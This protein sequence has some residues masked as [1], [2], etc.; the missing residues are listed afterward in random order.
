MILGEEENDYKWQQGDRIA[1]I[2]TAKQTATAVLLTER[3]IETCVKD[4]NLIE[5][6]G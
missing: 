2:L 6:L 3:R 5:Q 1:T 4:G